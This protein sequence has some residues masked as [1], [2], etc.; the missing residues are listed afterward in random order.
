MSDE[1][2]IRIEN[3][4]LLKHQNGWT[5]EHIAQLMGVSGAY[6]GKLINKKTAF[7][8]KTARHIEEVS[9]KPRMWMDIVHTDGKYSHSDEGDLSLGAHVLRTGNPAPLFAGE[10][11]NHVVL[12]GV[13]S[14]TTAPR[15]P[16]VE[17]AAL[18][19]DVLKHKREWPAEAYKS[20]TPVIDEV[21]EYVKMA[22]VIESPLSTIQPGDMVAIDPMAKPWDDCVIVLKI[23]SGRLVLRRYRA[24]S[25]GG[26]EAICPN[27]PPLDSTRHGITIFGVV[28]GLNKLRF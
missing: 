9:G 5:N 3:L 20:F 1:R 25:A 17:W 14:A 27:E 11:E 28:V 13:L 23:A 10:H 18:E 12:G 16:V 15:A 7:T 2:M 8:E 19:K 24:L 21:S 4:K 22:T 6:I 26:Y